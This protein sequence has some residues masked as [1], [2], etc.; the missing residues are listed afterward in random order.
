MNPLYILRHI[1]YEGPGY[2]EKVLYR[3]DI[4]F[5]LVALDEDDPVPDSLEKCSGLVIMGGPMSANDD[6]DWIQQEIT[7]IQNAI[8]RRLPVL[9]HCLGGQLIAKAL[10]ATIKNNPVKEI[11][12]HP[13]YRADPQATAG[14]L[15]H[16]RIPQNVF[17]W[18][19]ETFDIPEGAQH[20]LASDHCL[21][22]AF[23]YNNNVLAFQCH[24]EMTAD[25]VDQWS[26]LYK[27]EISTPS[28]TVQS[29]HDMLAGIELHIDNMHK[30]ADS[31]YDDWLS[32]IGA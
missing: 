32:K 31:I 5:Q 22:Q 6:L 3:K 2:L 10:G 12:W 23:Q 16:F 20:L 4:P 14:W 9:G 29:H 24:I 1:E 18:H 19:G 28:E 15:T 11:G 26:K 7:L 30:H 13:V 27:D 8:E 21:N 25:M 17:H